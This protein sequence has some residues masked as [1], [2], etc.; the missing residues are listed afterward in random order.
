MAKVQG[1]SRMAPDEI[2]F[3]LNRGGK[4]VMYR[5]CFSAILVTVMQSTDIYLIRAGQSRVVKGLPWCLLTLL[6]GWWGIPWGP[7]RSIQSLWINLRGGTNVTAA[8]ANGL[9]LSG[10]KWDVAGAP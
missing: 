5:Y 4:F 2:A 9:N 6:A 10:V 1:I 8:V 7:I 3:E